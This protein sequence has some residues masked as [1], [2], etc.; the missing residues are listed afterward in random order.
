MHKFIKNIFIFLLI[1]IF[2][3]AFSSSYS[4]LSI[5]NLAYVLAIGID[6]SDKDKLQ[7]TF[8]FSSTVAATESGSSQKATPII[9]TVDASSVSNA[10]NL[11]NSYMVKEINM[12]HCKAI[13]FSEELAYEGIS[14]EIYT[15]INDTQVRPSS[16][17]VVSKCK[18]KDYIKY[19]QPELENSKYK[20]YE[21]MSNSSKYTGYSIDSSIGNFF[22]SLSCKGCEPYA[23]LGGINQPNTQNS[24]SIN[25]QKDSNIKANESAIEGENEAENIGV[26]VFKGDTL[27]GEL[28]AIETV[29]FSI[30]KGSLNRF[31][32]SVPDPINQGNYLDIYFTPYKPPNIKIDTSSASP[33]VHV[34]AKLSGRIYSMSKN[35]R[36]LEPRILD[37]ISES[38][39]S[40]LESAISNV[41]Y[42]TSI[43]FNSDVMGIGKCAFSNFLTTQDFDNYNWLNNYQHAFFDIDIDSS[44]KSGMLITET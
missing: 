28:N 36:Y 41:F 9:N 2:I 19:T 32:V 4:S 1:I 42:K 18:A 39:N 17:I 15:L 29:A 7:V 40:Y 11:I 24:I 16:N 22:N 34:K 20:Y 38:C 33:Y 25:S 44:V 37:T 30:L 8:E 23:I 3:I 27:V 21:I 12:S 31:L 43:D 5:D 26:A 10:I 35:S 13:I 14:D 6:K